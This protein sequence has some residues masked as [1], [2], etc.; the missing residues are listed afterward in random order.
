MLGEHVLDLRGIDVLA[1]TDDHVT[2]AAARDDQPTRR[3][4]MAEIPG[5]QPALPVERRGGLFR[6]VV[7][8]LHDHGAAHLDLTGGTRLQDGPGRGIGHAQLEAGERRAVSNRSGSS[9]DGQAS[10]VLASVWP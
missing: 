6:L 3:A 10:S 1:S 8:A 7:V 9:E 5:P 4:E 2:Q